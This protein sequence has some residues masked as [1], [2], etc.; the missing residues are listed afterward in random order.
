[1]QERFHYMKNLILME[2]DVTCLKRKCFSC[3]NKAHL[4][5]EC[6]SIHYIPDKEKVI[7]EYD[8]S[9]PQQRFKKYVR[10]SKRAHNARGLKKALN[11]I[12]QVQEEEVAEPT[13]GQYEISSLKNINI[14]NNPSGDNNP[15][16]GGRAIN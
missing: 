7:K 1:M 4:A 2:K 5:K 11:E 10:N 14:Q 16:P 13:S 15:N 8:F 9:H 12:F 3:S 6:P